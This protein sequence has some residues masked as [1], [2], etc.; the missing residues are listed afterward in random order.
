MSHASDMN[1]SCP[2]Y[3]NESDP[4]CVYP[5]IKGEAHVSRNRRPPADIPIHHAATHCNTLQHTATHCNT[6]QHTT[7]QIYRYTTLQRTATHCNTLQH[8]CN[9]TATP[10]QHTATHC[11]TLQHTATHDSA[12]IP[13]HLY[14]YLYIHISTLYIYPFV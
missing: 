7:L 12:D 3:M 1:G 14:I 10:L 9:T 6:V 8:H 5:Y 13:I 2:I 11:N 4:R